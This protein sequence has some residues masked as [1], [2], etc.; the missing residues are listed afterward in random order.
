[1]RCR[2]GGSTSIRSTLKDLFH[3]RSSAGLFFEK[4]CGEGYHRGNQLAL[5]KSSRRIVEFVVFIA[6]ILVPVLAAGPHR[7]RG[8]PATAIGWSWAVRVLL[9]AAVA[10]LPSSGLATPSP[11]LRF[12]LPSAIEHDHYELYQRVNPDAGTIPCSLL[13]RISARLAKT[14]LE[15]NGANLSRHKTPAKVSYPIIHLQL[16]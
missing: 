10:R 12:F 3:R 5:R 14:R 16:G 9:R 11:R 6:K 8:E 2:R 13:V 4:G 1:M 15:R 7:T